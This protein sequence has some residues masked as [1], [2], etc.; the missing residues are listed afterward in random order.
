MSEEQATTESTLSNGVDAL[1]RSMELGSLKDATEYAT[2]EA[3][4][5]SIN[6]VCEKVIELEEALNR[7]RKDV[8]NGPNNIAALNARLDALEKVSPT[9]VRVTLQE[10]KDWTGARIK[11]VGTRLGGNVSELMLEQKNIHKRL[12]ELGDRIG[13]QENKPDFDPTG[14]DES[15]TSL[16]KTV[17][18]LRQKAESRLTFDATDFETRLARL[19]EGIASQGRLQETFIKKQNKLQTCIEVLETKQNRLA[20]SDNEIQQTIMA[21]LGSLERTK[22]PPVSTGKLKSSISVAKTAPAKKPVGK[23]KK[24]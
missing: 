19:E 17:E 5:K 23:A 14:M 22:K 21:R 20:D 16:N 15:I 2:K 1:N 6:D 9:E 12:I 4:D 8:V 7:F 3:V 24:K 11:D 18:Q 13:T 10:I